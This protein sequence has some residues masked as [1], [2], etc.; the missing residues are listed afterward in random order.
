LVI[1]ANLHLARCARLLWIGPSA[2]SKR[3]GPAR[4]IAVHKGKRGPYQLVDRST[5]RAY[6]PCDCR[7]SAPGALR[8]AAM[9]RAF[10]PQQTAR[11]GKIHHGARTKARTVSA[12][13]IDLWGGLTALGDCRESA[14]GALRQAG[15]NRAFGP[16]QTARTGKI[17]PGAQR[18]APKV[19]T[20]SAW[21]EA[22]GLRAPREPRAE[23]PLHRVLRQSCWAGLTA[24]GQVLPTRPT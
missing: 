16:Q 7:E 6:S 13:R 15:M 18:K 3:R 12:L 20:I 5:G 11:I 2:L 23:G 9:D 14:P 21:G 4:S 24:R 19:R 17:H 10:G 8:Q 22:P 1:V